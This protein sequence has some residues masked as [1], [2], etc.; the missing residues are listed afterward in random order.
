MKKWSR[1]NGTMFTAS[2]LRSAF[3]CGEKIV[4]K[5]LFLYIILNSLLR[6]HT[7][8]VNMAVQHLFVWTGSQEKKCN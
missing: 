2:F 6:A 8:N 5:S 3:S 7:P 1:G 4:S